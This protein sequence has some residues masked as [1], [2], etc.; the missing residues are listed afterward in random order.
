MEG[1]ATNTS[2]YQFFPGTV[3]S[4]TNADAYCKGMGYRLPAMETHA[5]NDFIFGI[6]NSNYGK[7]SIRDL[8]SCS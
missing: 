3:M 6:L 2:I 4:W 8:D 5:E 7:K 1:L